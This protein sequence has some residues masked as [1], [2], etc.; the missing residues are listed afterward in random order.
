VG[1]N[2]AMYVMRARI[3]DI[4]D[5]FDITDESGRKV[6]HVDGK[7]LTLRDRV[8]L[9][10]VDG[11]EVAQVHRR[12]VA[13]HRTYEVSIGGEPVAQVRKNF[14]TPFRDKFTIDIPGPH[15]LSMRGN[16][17]D[18]EFTIERDGATVATVSKRWLSIRDTY[19]VEIA[20]GEND[21]LILAAVIALDLSQKRDDEQKH[22]DKDE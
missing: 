7:T 18:H 21:V 1:E 8:V 5:D 11:N 6:F 16:L 10:D 2:Q 15:D 4:G 14:L 3:F 9:A 20:Q 17:L 22:D 12:L 13:L 19:A